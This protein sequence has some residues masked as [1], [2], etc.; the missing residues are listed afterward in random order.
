[1]SIRISKSMSL[2]DTTDDAVSN[3]EILLYSDN[4]L[5]DTLFFEQNGI[6]SSNNIF[7]KENVNY[8]LK[9]N[10]P[11]FNEISSE[12]SLPYKI[13]PHNIEKKENVAY[14]N[15]GNLYSQ[16][17]VSFYDLPDYNNYYEIVLLESFNIE[18]AT[19]TIPLVVFSNDEVLLNEGD[20]NY[21]ST[22]LPF[23][24]ELINGKEYELCLNYYPPA[25]DNYKLIFHFRSVCEDYYLYKKTIIRH[26]NNQSSDIWDGLG[27]PVSMYSNVENGFGIFAGYETVIDTIN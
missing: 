19:I 23:S 22:Y 18:G 5:S 27:E 9:V 26:L 14:D 20:M 1:M 24:D 4:V 15:D 10:S 3:A 2:F 17:F 21:Y 11:G 25:V 16:L 7:P 13:F 8:K 12:S 6:Y